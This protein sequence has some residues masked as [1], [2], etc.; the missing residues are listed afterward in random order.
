M[1]DAARKSTPR[2]RASVPREDLEESASTPPG[3]ER[4]INQSAGADNPERVRADAV[5]VAIDHVREAMDALQ[6]V[7]GD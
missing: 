1:L 7:S 2:V 3:T 6:L 4:W 5:A